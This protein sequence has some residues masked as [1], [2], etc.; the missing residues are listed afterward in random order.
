[1]AA[2]LFPSGVQLAHA[3]E[4]HE[5]EA[6]YEITVHL[7]EEP[8]DCPIDHFHFSVYDCRFSTT[9]VARAVVFFNQANFEYNEIPTIFS[10]RFIS[11]RGPPVPAV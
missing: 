6:C 5:H 10:Q 4:G 2:L 11:L 9:E 7:H 3:L 8:V 1:M